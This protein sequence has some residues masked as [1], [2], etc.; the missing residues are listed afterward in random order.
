M[1]RGGPNFFFGGGG[2]IFIFFLVKKKIG[3]FQN[4]TGRG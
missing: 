3:E 1:G 4:H 2:F